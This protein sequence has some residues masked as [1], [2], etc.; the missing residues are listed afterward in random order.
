MNSIEQLLS[1]KKYNESVSECISLKYIHLAS[2]LEYSL[3]KG[4]FLNTVTQNPVT[5]TESVALSTPTVVASTDSVATLNTVT[6]SVA[7]LNTVT[8][9][10]D[11]TCNT[12]TDSVATL[13]TEVIPLNN[14]GKIRIKVVCSWT[15]SVSI[16]ERMNIFTKG[17]YCWNNIELVLENPDYYI[18]LNAPR[19]EFD[20]KKSI[21]FQMEPNMAKNAHVWREWADPTSKDFIKVCKHSSEYNNLEWH[22]GKTYTEFKTIEIKKTESVISTVLSAKYHDP[23]HIKRVDFVKFLEKKDVTVHVFGDNKW[24]YKDYKGQLPFHEKENG[25]FPYKYTFNVENH[26]IKNYCTE[27][28]ADAILSE[29]LCFYSGCYNVKE[30]ID[31]RAFVYLEL[32]N[33]EKDCLTIRKAIEEDLWSQRLPYIRAAKKKILDYL[34]I[35]PRIERIITKTEDVQYLA[36]C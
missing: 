36:D 20:I 1:E 26:S 5:S 25:L 31:E 18:I 13:N 7:T 17:N 23:G 6:E 9:S 2:L 14:T 12:V 19:D 32:S 27:K 29:C 4:D 21:L 10:V 24:E 16:R 33:F 11:A 35:M 30:Y 22:I 28:L 15:D 3:L 8:D 34:Q